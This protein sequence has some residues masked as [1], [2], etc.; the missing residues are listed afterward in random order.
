V[1]KSLKRFI[2]AGVI[3]AGL[4]GIVVA[5][6]GRGQ[7]PVTQELIGRVTAVEM[8]NQK[9]SRFTVRTDRGQTL[10]VRIDFKRTMVSKG[11]R[12]QEPSQLRVGDRVRVQAEV[13]KDRYLAKDIRI[14]LPPPAKPA[15][16]PPATRK[17]R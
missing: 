1:L 5:G 11:G 10:H 15:A 9:H 4:L 8:A 16:K 3:L 14:E 12:M 2:I 17:K 6:L 7:K 13:R